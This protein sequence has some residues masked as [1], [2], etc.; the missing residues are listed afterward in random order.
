M[1][2]PIAA[3]DLPLASVQWDCRKVL[4][5]LLTHSLAPAASLVLLSMMPVAVSAALHLLSADKVCFGY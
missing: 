5:A 3:G 2:M 4:R 1:M